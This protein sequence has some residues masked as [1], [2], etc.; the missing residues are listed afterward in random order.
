MK[1]P[2]HFDS[3]TLFSVFILHLS[4]ADREEYVNSLTPNHG[5]PDSDSQ[6]MI[7]ETEEE[8]KAMRDRMNTVRNRV[9][10]TTASY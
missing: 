4:I 1:T 8:I 3:S 2:K 9:K 6:F 5:K 7:D 10:K